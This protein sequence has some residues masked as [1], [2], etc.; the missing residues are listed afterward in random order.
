MIHSQ[1]TKYQNVSTNL[2][3][4]GYVEYSQKQI[5]LANRLKEMQAH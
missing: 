5:E 2:Q 1:L 4:K 3:N